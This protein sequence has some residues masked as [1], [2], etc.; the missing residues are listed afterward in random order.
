MGRE[1]KSRVDFKI[2]KIVNSKIV[3]YDVCGNHLSNTDK[4]VVQYFPS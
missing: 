3:T 1:C 4:I 2:A